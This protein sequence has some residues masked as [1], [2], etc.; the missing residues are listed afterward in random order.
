MTMVRA[1]VSIRGRVQGV[2]FRIS[3]R[4][5]ALARGVSG[6]VRNLTDGSV[7]M[8]AQ[9]ERPAVESLLA[10]CRQGPPRARVDEVLVQWEEAGGGLAG[11]EVR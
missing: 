1:R 5:E 7:E 9:G 2:Y 3:T 11:F 8:V 10:W 6:W 4:E